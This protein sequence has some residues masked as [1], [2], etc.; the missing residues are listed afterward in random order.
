[1]LGSAV[2][3][4][5]VAG[6][7][8]L[9]VVSQDTRLEPNPAHEDPTPHCSVAG[10]GGRVGAV[11]ELQGAEAWEKG[12][13]TGEEA[14]GRDLEDGTQGVLQARALPQALGEA[15]GYRV[16]SPVEEPDG[17]SF[18]PDGQVK[19]RYGSAGG[20]GDDDDGG[21]WGDGGD[22][23]CCCSGDGCCCCGGGG[24]GVGSDGLSA[25][26]DVS[27]EGCDG[28]E[29]V[30]GIALACSE[31]V[32]CDSAAAPRGE[33]ERKE[34]RVGR[35]LNLTWTAGKDAA[36]LGLGCLPF[37]PDPRCTRYLDENVALLRLRDACELR[38]K[39]GAAP[40]R[41]GSSPGCAAAG[42]RGSYDLRGAAPS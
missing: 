9:P 36:F 39:S 31:G 41:T 4:S 3:Q 5:E 16:G 25:H 28:F 29:G 7:V 40:L 34:L 14:S 1:M 15:A 42:S 6:L 26:A 8:V 21:H 19:G 32:V 37:C 2:G 17:G 22:C 10:K 12:L 11:D 23:C 27:L 20:G 18:H 13:E 38:V 33:W 35:S 24:G 30:C